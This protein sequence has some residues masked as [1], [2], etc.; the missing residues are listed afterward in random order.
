MRALI[1]E[2]ENQAVNALE[3]E[4]ADNCPEIQ[5][6]GQAAT[7][8][9]AEALIRDQDPEIV[10][11]DIQL[12][13]GTGFDLLERLGNYD[14]KVIF[15]TA[16]GQYALQAIKISALDYLLKPIGT[17]ELV[18]AVNKAKSTDARMVN[19]Q[20]M[21][22]IENQKLNLP[23]KKIALPTSKGISLYEIKTVVRIQAE[24]NYSGLY[25]S[26]GQKIIV[27]RTLKEFEDTL[28]GM[29]FVRIHHSH[30]IN[31]DHLKSYISKDGGYVVMSNNENLPVSKRKKTDLLKALG[32]MA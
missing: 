30:I 25:M 21:N 4:L 13:D 32:S 29:G 7:V 28:R 11:L 10:F 9:E 8:S 17:E 2:D 31:I 19:N 16:Y 5:V 18:Q 3:Q 23:R 26:N 14:F 12:K 22:L 1:I 15:T 20:I 24:G 27:A 6:C